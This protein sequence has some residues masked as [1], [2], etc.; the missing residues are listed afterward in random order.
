MFGRRKKMNAFLFLFFFANK[1]KKNKDFYK[2]IMKEK[3]NF[4]CVV[5]LLVINLLWN[6]IKHQKEGF[7][8]NRKAKLR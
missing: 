3:T 6:E 5:F 1:L 7:R 8:R 4:T 2:I